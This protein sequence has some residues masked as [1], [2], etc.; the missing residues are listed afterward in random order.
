[1]KIKFIIIFLI[2]HFNIL[3]AQ[4]LSIDFGKSFPGGSFD[5]D[6]ES[7]FT[8]GFSPEFTIYKSINLKPYFYYCSFK[9]NTGGIK[10]GDSDARNFKFNKHDIISFGT[11]VN[12]GENREMF[13]SPY[14][15]A[16]LGYMIANLEDITYIYGP[17]IEAMQEGYHFRG[18]MINLGFGLQLNHFDNIKPFTEFSYLISY[19]EERISARK[20]FTYYRLSIG[21]KIYLFN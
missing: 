15:Q 21:F 10:E 19:P 7:D 8:F 4:S 17:N 12:F 3:F 14:F 13:I 6:W 1:M 20:E 9:F 5:S 18:M 16:G 11:M 2:L